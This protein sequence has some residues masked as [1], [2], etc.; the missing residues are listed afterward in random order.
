V[1]I[2]EIR[3]VIDQAVKRRLS[4][5]MRQEMRN[6]S[7]FCSLPS[8]SGGGR[9][10]YYHYYYS[11]PEILPTDIRFIILD[12]LKEPKDILNILVAFKWQWQIPDLYWRSRFPKDILFEFDEII[13]SKKELDWQYLCLRA[14]ELLETCHGLRNRRRIMRVLEGTKSVF[15]QTIEQD[16]EQEKLGT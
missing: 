2:I 10:Y 14:E 12:L 4:E 1:N 11:R 16:R 8:W 15:L 13:T 9:Y 5:R 3:D 7:H 6:L